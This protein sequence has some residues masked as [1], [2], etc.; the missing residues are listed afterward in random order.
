MPEQPKRQVFLSV[1]FQQ[2]QKLQQEFSVILGVLDAFNLHA[3]DFVA[4]FSFSPDEEQAMMQTALAH[5]EASSLLIAEVSQKA[6]GVGIEIGYAV[7]K[8]IPVVYLRKQGSAYSTTVGGVA[9]AM[10]VYEDAED[11]RVKLTQV[12]EDIGFIR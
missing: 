9:H 10:V 5:I 2:R 6:I 4:Q 7:G 1:G 11:L 12:L 8:G 3:I